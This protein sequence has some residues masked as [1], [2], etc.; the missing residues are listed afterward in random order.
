MNKAVIVFVLFLVVGSIIVIAET[1]NTEC[2]LWCKV[3]RFLFG[4][5]ENRAGQGWFD[6]EN[7][8]GN[9]AYTGNTHG[10]SCNNGNCECTSESCFYAGISYNKDSRIGLVTEQDVHENNNKLAW[11]Y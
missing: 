7:V 5:P 3:S 1:E 2:G 8:V 11:H 9:V 4:N 6:R 10:W